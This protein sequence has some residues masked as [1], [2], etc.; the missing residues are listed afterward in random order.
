P[1]ITSLASP[2]L[3]TPVLNRPSRVTAIGTGSKRSRSIAA[4]TSVA[5][6]IE[7]SCSEDLPPYIRARR[8]LGMGGAESIRPDHA[9]REFAQPAIA[10]GLLLRAP[11]P[12]RLQ[13]VQRQL[14]V[15]D[16]ARVK[17]RRQVLQERQRH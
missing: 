13:I 7:T 6:R 17:V 5:L 1:S 14:V 12:D 3:A 11:T 16:L 4:R 9:G 15:G 2:W 8:C 10:P